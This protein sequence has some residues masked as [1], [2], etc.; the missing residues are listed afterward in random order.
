MRGNRSFTIHTD[1]PSGWEL[2]VAVF[3]DQK[4]AGGKVTA[5]ECG[6][7][8]KI[9]PTKIINSNLITLYGR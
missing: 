3:V 4:P 5:R 7:L 9:K 6:L 8:E 2:G 1:E